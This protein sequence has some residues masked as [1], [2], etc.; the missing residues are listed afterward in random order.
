ME[1]KENL[2]LLLRRKH[3][4]ELLGISDTL[5]YNMVNNNVLPTIYY[6]ERVY[7]HRDRFFAL[8]D[9]LRGDVQ[10]YGNQTSK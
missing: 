4:K 7:V 3:V 10:K 2:P 6:N 1:L 8:L 5:Y 9:S